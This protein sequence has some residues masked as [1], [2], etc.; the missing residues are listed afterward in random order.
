M[1]Y[2]SLRDGEKARLNITK[3]QEDEISKLYRQVYL[4]LKKKM[5]KLSHSGTTSESLRKTYL[6]K[7]V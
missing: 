1:G 6:N 3:A 4:D 7:M 2:I 5:D